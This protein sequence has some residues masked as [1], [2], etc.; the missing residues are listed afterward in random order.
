V[1][2]LLD[3]LHNMTASCVEGRD[4][5]TLAREQGELG[6]VIER[7]LQEFG[8]LCKDYN[9]QS[10][11]LVVVRL[12]ALRADKDPSI[13]VKEMDDRG[14]RDAFVLELQDF[15]KAIGSRFDV[16]VHGYQTCRETLAKRRRWTVAL[17]ALSG[18]IALAIL[19]ALW[20]AIRR[21]KLGPAPGAGSLIH[22]NYRLLRET[23]RRNWGLVFEAEDI[24]LKRRTIVEMISEDLTGERS[25]LAKFLEAARRASALKHDNLLET[26]AMF[27]EGGRL[28]LVCEYYAGQPLDELL[29]DG[30]RLALAPAKLLLKQAAGALDYVHSRGLLYGFLHP[31]VIL[32]S[33]EGSVKLMDIA[34]AHGMRLAGKQAAGADSGGL[35]AYGAPELARGQACAESDLFSLATIARELLSGRQPDAARNAAMPAAL[36]AV[37]QRA[38]H[39]D[40]R[41][42]YHSGADFMTALEA[43][44]DTSR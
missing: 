13:A 8:N 38:L 39:Q 43:V 7:K 15:R 42:R 30:R 17:K 22:G 36:Q 24:A 23:A 31:A 27:E 4:S 5:S 37:F 19:A 20:F 25:A 6:A 33:R 28:F 2:Q 26:Y 16:E 40:T 9:S 34:V 1:V 29:A 41:Q 44:P 21:R 10:D 11:A 14:S 3:R 12:I 35:S 32:V 18:A